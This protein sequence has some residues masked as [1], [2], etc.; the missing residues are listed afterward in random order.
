[1]IQWSKYILFASALLVSLLPSVASANDKDPKE[2]ADKSKSE[3]PASQPTVDL[4]KVPDGTNE[5]LMA[6]LKKVMAVEP[7]GTDET[8]KILKTILKTTDKILD[9]NPNEKDLKTVISIRMELPMSEDEYKAFADKLSKIGG[10]LTNSGKAEFGRD[11]ISI[12]YWVRIIA[13]RGK[14]EEFKKAIDASIKYLS[15]GKLQKSDMT[16]VVNIAEAAERT[17]DAKFAVATLEKLLALLKE[18]K[19]EKTEKLVKNFEGSIRRLK[20]VGNKIELEGNLLSGGKLDLKKYEGKVVL[21]DFWATWCLSCD[22]DASLLKKLY[23][24]Y[25]DKGFE[26]IGLSCDEN[27][28]AVEKFVKKNEIPWATVYGDDGPSPSFDYYGISGVP[29]K[30]L[31]GR[32]GKVIALFRRADEL[33]KLLEKPLGPGEKKAEKDE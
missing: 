32:D 8:L 3:A 2:P 9:A 15:D 21:V 7:K 16:M 28:E 22:K 1:M 25:H 24:A 23:E 20:L 14:P 17:D 18:S 19:I 4:E 31:V 10:D 27:R 13:A 5:E 11:V 6:Y 29:V 12:S 33:A 26:I 30:M